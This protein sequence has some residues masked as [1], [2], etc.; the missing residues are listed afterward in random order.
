MKYPKTKARL[1][2]GS[3]IILPSKGTDY[4]SAPAELCLKIS[5]PLGGLGGKTQG[6]GVA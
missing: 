2:T 1:S 6:Q 4:K 5:P 3:L